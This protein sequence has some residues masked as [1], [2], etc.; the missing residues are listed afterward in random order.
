MSNTEKIIVQVQVKGQR[1]LDN[2]SKT[3]KKA[4]RS[5]GDLTKGFGRMAAGITSAVVAFRTINQVIGGSIRS[6]RDFEFQMAKVRA[7]T[8]ASDKDFKLLSDTAKDLGRSTFFTAQQVS[9]LQTN[10]G[11]LGFSTQEI[12]DAQE[13]TLL[14]A[15]ATDTDLAR[16][17][18]VA[19]ASVRGFGLDAEETG[20]IVDVMAVAF[21]SSALDIEKFQTSMTKVAPIAAG[22]GI[23]MESTTAVMASLTDAGIEASIAGTSLRNIFL[24][25]QDSSSDLSKHLGFTVNSSDDLQRALT[26]LN[27][28]ALD[29]EEIMGLVDIRQV[30]AFRTMIEGSDRIKNLT[31][32][33]NAASGEA[34]RMANI[35]G[36]TLEGSFKRL[37]SAT[38]GLAIELTQKLGGG[39]QDLVD[40][41]A[42]FFNRLTDNSDGLVRLIRN[43]VQVT[44]FLGIYAAGLA[45]VRV[46]TLAYN[47][48]TF[49]ATNATKLFTKALARTGIG[50]AVIAL[51][52]LIA[53]FTG[54][55][56]ETDEATKKLKEFEEAQAKILKRNERFDRLINQQ[57]GN[58]IAQ[59]KKIIENL[60][61]EKAKREAV[62]IAAKKGATELNDEQKKLF[63]DEI[64]RLK[65]RIR[66]EKINGQELVKNKK[67]E[68]TA[69]RSLIVEQEKLLDLANRMPETTEAEIAVKNKKI[70]SIEAEIDRLKN[71]GIE[72]EK[73]NK[74][75]R[76]EL[77][78]DLELL[79]FKSG[80]MREGNLSEQQ[81]AEVRRE[82]IQQE[83]DDSKRL[84]EQL[85]ISGEQREFLMAKIV[86]LEKELGQQSSE[87]K[88]ARLEEDIVTAALSGKNAE[89]SVKSVIRAYIMESIAGHI[90]SIMTN[91]LIPFPINLAL[92]AGAGIAVGQLVD[93][94]LS[95]VKFAKG[96]TVEEFA[97]GGMVHGKS[98]AFGGEKFAVGGR[99]VELEGGE[100]V[101]NK[102]STAMF[103]GQLSAMNAAGGGVK[104]ADGGLLNMPSFTQQQFNA[105]GQNQMMGAVS[106]GSKVVVVESDITQAQQSVSVIE[107]QV[108]F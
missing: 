34:R 98:H 78:V 21:R 106:Q 82:L 38:E 57:V 47:A 56:K 107:S 11:K 2:L 90:R 53:K 9:E 28:Q 108:T 61:F 8:S 68:T 95:S 103:K 26:L 60:K 39:L 76:A 55:G 27:S 24:K 29:N 79:D 23:S 84:L 20:R 14:L 54:L 73:V 25:M 66:L 69:A 40:K 50:L 86:Q 94:G 44:K 87:D 12:L 65:E 17:A 81:A 89:E 6:F 31:T 37:R 91:P 52:S 30:A 72:Q 105:V 100:A 93:K 19:G 1:D 70:Q 77:D 10:F 58:S 71:L 67:Q 85:V 64:R 7:V 104:F 96:G 32:D 75:K 63:E 42:D 35:V 51:G 88:K 4:S 49:L 92:A 80:Q 41:L 3:T 62:L 33:F 102:R 45:T 5:A 46:A 83:I 97:N 59:S 16:A 74:A 36:D 18:I 48:V 15:T 22:A 43:I 101:I 13:A 99:V